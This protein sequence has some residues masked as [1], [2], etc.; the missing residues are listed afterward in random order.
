MPQLE[1]AAVI[2][3]RER[4]QSRLAA[5]QAAAA[6]KRLAGRADAAKLTVPLMLEELCARR[7]RGEEVDMR[8]RRRDDVLQELQRVRTTV[9]DIPQPGLWA[10]GEGDDDS[11]EASNDHEQAAT[12]PGSLVGRRAI[13]WYEWPE[14]GPPRAE[15]LRATVVKYRPRVRSE[16]KYLLHYDVDGED[17]A[18]GG[19]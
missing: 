15:W 2:A 16:L 8:V 11:R 1:G 10:G 6:A 7:E 4:V 12:A 18:W 3:I 19:G 17:F 9:P 13:A 5:Q 14:S